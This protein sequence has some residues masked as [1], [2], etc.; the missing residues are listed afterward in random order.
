MDSVYLRI[1]SKIRE[2]RKMHGLTLEGLSDKAE[3]DWSFLARI[4]RG[5]AIPSIM[6]LIKITKALNITMEE[7]FS[8]HKENF[9]K[10]ENLLERAILQTV[11][12]LSVPEKKRIFEIIRLAIT[13]HK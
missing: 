6:T 3:L 5:K 11:K 12:K 7:L 1:G 9:P 4:E 2:L 13:K 10:E 8:V